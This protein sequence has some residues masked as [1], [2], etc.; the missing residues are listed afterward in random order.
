MPK[1]KSKRKNG[2]L[3]KYVQRDYAGNPVRARDE[4]HHKDVRIRQMMRMQTLTNAC[5]SLTSAEVQLAIEAGKGHEMSY[6]S[7]TLDDNGVPIDGDTK[8]IT[9][10]NLDVN[11]LQSILAH[12][13]SIEGQ[14]LEDA[15]VKE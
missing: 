7:T 4:S 15:G 2:K 9:L 6:I 5:E 13:E 1:S 12:K 10:A 11:R 8:L 14:I 3:N